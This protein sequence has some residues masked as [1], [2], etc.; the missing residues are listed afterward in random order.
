MSEDDIKLLKTIINQV[1]IALKQAKLYAQTKKQAE[2]EKFIREIT[3]STRNS[4]DVQENSE[5]LVKMVAEEFKPD[6]CFIDHLTAKKMFP[7]C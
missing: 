1:V 6:K 4:L 2:R 3:E 7:S 5:Q